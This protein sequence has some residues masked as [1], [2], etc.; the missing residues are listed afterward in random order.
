[1]RTST[2]LLLLVLASGPIQAAEDPVSGIQPLSGRA[3]A[4]MPIQP[5]AVYQQGV[6]AIIP[7]LIL[8]GEWTSI[9]KLTNRSD[10][11]IPTTNVYFIDN[12]GNP[13]KTAFQTS[14]G[15]PITD[16]GFSFSLVPGGMIEVTFFGGSDTN[17]GH[18]LIDLC[19]SGPCIPGLYGEVTLRNRNSTRPDFES[20]FPLEQ[21]TALQYMLWDHRNG[22]ST[23]LYLVNES[24]TASSVTLDFTN[25]ANQ[26]VRSVG[27]TLPALGSQILTLNALAPETIGIQGTLAIRG[28]AAFITA[29]AL[30]IN[31]SNSFTP[32]R[33]FVPKL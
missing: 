26:L 5:R 1:M 30:R 6:E 25:T 13:M 15:N 4:G 20:V 3:F 24:T 32:M 27:V 23:V 10:K 28:G 22:V 31:P 2:S 19:H 9:I 11:P 21:P 18:G 16:V 29:T 12:A 7:E 14:A 33:A 8:G 17:F